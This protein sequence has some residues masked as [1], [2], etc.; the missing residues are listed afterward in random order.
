VSINVLV[1]DDSAVMRSIIVKTLRLSGI[2]LGDVHQASNGLE[3]LQALD[4][5][6]IDLA[7]VDINMPV[8][9]GQEMINR[10]REDPTMSD[11]PMV[12]VSTESS[13]SRIEMLERMGTRFVHKPFTPER[14]RAT[15]MEATGIQEEDVHAAGTVSGSSPDF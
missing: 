12:V 5:N 1:V 6:W 2:E 10:V 4:D 11:L 7:L 8:M 15:I 3:G 14:L 9:D 13:E